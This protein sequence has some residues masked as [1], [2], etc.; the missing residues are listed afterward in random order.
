MTRARGS[1][2]HGRP[3][4]R[5][6]TSPRPSYPR[7]PAPTCLRCRAPG[8]G[9]GSGRREH[10][11][12]PRR[13]RPGNPDQKEGSGVTSC[14]GTHRRSVPPGRR[15]RLSAPQTLR[16]IGSSARSA[17]VIGA[18]VPHAP[19]SLPERSKACRGAG[20]RAGVVC[21]SVMALNRGPRRAVRV[22]RARGGSVAVINR[23]HAPRS[24]M[25]GMS[26]RVPRPLAVTCDSLRP[27]TNTS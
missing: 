24:N 3:V 9:A 12:G 20:Y 19:T 15:R 5:P 22:G 26:A 8:R 27:A 25:T 11:H 7:S 2:G 14:R 18:R 4:A 17:A 13:P 10:L 6:E 21:W 23:H 1:A 16:R